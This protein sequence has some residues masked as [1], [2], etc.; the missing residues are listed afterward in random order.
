MALPHAA[1]QRQSA[2]SRYF[3]PAVETDALIRKHITLPPSLP[4]KKTDPYVFGASGHGYPVWSVFLI[5]R[6]AGGDVDRTLAD[7]DGDLTAEQ[8]E[9]VT[10]FAE[11]YPDAVLPFVEAAL[12]GG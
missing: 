10:R 11:R 12:G 3:D 4:G 2:R 9:A 7:Y 1:G 8:I 5:Y 6:V